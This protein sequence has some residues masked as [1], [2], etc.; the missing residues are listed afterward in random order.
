MRFPAIDET[1]LL[2]RLRP[3]RGKLRMV[4]DTDTYNEIDDQFA[5]VY[6]L[7]SPESMQVEAIYAAP[8]SNELTSVPAEGMEMSYQE[9]LRLLKRL[10]VSPEG[11]VFRG[12]TG[13]LSDWEHP[14]RSA[15]AL[16]LVSKAMAPADEPLYVVAIGAITNVAS[17]ILIEPEIINRIVL[18]WLGGQP[19]YWPSARHF[20]IG[21]DLHASRL[22][23]D[24]GVP[25]VHVPCD[26]VTS[27]LLTSVP[28]IEHHVR[29]RG[30]IGDYLFEIFKAYVEKHGVLSKEIWD[31]STIAYLI[32]DKWVPTEL[33]H[34]PI[35][36][37]QLTWSIDHSR[38]LMRQ[39]TF[40]HRDPIFRDLF[41]KLSNRA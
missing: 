6:S 21:Q 22:V 24:C 7:L 27:H 35:L 15:A 20:N 34:S 31:I 40:V 30:A 28:E 8:F 32:N 19:L 2:Q 4:L 37:D 14:E 16:D 9:I 36:T 33:V 12:S 39:A 11:F 38:H 10:D 17:A 3:P 1:M 23:F 5:V 25:L 41:A 29:G 26:G 13:Y 18:V